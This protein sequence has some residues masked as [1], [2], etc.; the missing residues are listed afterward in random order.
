MFSP[1]PLAVPAPQ[2]GG[3]YRPRREFRLPED[4]EDY[5]DGT[6]LLWETLLVAQQPWVVVYG[7]ALPAGYTVDETAVAVLVTTGYP[8]APLDMAYFS[9]PLALVS[10]RAIPNAGFP[11]T[12][13]GQAWQGW[14]RHRTPANPWELG[15]D[16]LKTHLALVR[17]WLAHEV[18]R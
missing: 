4:D 16:S 17:A 14:S 18:T 10:G 7:L 15:V 12:I 8:A 3:G 9:P 11:Q 2:L 13:D 5:L 6:G 1:S